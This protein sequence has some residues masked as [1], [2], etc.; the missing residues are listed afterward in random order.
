MSNY[1]KNKQLAITMDTTPTVTDQA[2]AND[3]DINVIVRRYGSTGMVPG[4]P[5]PPMGGDF[6]ELPEDLRGFIETSRDLN[7]RMEKLPPQLRDLNINQ[8][9]AL[10]PDEVANKLTPPAPPPDNKPTDK[11][12]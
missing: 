11:P 4:A 7:R 6:T 3:T 1:A 10:T 8:L 5:T 12:A 2:G 9:L